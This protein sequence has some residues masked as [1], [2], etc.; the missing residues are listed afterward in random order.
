MTQI[1]T[2]AEIVARLR[3]RGGELA[4]YFASIP[5]PEF[6]SGDT[7]HWGPAH[8]LGH[9]ALSHELGARGFE[10][11]YRAAAHPTGRSR[12]LEV[13]RAIYAENLAAPPP[14]FVGRNPFTASFKTGTTREQV[15]ERYR[16]A[17]DR[18]C[19]TAS[20]WTEEELDS[21]AMKHPLFGEMTAREMLQFFVDHDRHHL[22]GVVRRRTARSGPAA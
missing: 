3:S 6:F 7:T 18:L 21:R 14:A 19:E 8:H 2:G 4:D 12:P 16:A 22:N 17:C 1:R 20:G 10:H 11:K 5:E 15:I 9:L 13:M